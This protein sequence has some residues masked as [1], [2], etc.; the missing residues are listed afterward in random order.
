MDLVYPQ[1]S[2][3][4]TFYGTAFEGKF[5]IELMRMNHQSPSK[6]S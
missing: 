1:K 4:Q 5:G 3:F 2:I 6:G